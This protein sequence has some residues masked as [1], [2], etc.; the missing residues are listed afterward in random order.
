MNKK[1]N[2]VRF[3]LTDKMGLE[4]IKFINLKK[5]LLELKKLYNLDKNDKLLLKIQKI[6]SK[7]NKCRNTFIKEFQLSNQ[8]EIT[9]YLNLKDQ[10]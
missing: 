1:I 2:S 10:K 7:M 3:N 4:L 5:E 9:K 8:E 6:E